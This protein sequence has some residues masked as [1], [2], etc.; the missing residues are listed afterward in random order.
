M[1]KRLDVYKRQ[2]LPY[3]NFKGGTF[4]SIGIT[5][6]LAIIGVIITGYLLIKNVKGGILFGILTVSSTHLAVYKRQDDERV[7]GAGGKST[8]AGEKISGAS[9]H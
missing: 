1:G 4:H 5:A 7:Y 3:Q 6:L 8:Y 2:L 9:H